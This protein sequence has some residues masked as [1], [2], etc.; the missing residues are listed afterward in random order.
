MEI[1]KLL[2]LPL[3][4]ILKDLQYN[5]WLVDPDILAASAQIVEEQADIIDINMD[6]LS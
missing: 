4:Q 1:R 2:T 6:V 5:F 3:L